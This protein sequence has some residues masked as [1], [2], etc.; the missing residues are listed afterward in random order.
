MN[1]YDDIPV[2]TW[3]EESIPDVVKSEVNI[4]TLRRLE[5]E[6]ICVALE[7]SNCLSASDRRPDYDI[8]QEW[9]FS[10]SSFDQSFMGQMRILLFGIGRTDLLRVFLLH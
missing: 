8:M 9:H 2:F 3:L 10:V 7:D 6:A 1:K 5:A 4:V